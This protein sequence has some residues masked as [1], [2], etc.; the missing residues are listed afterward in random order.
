MSKRKAKKETETRSIEN[1]LIP[2][3]S[4]EALA[5]V[6]GGEVSDA[7]VNVTP[8]VAMSTTAVW[9]AVQLL[10]GAIG[11]LPMDV[12][13]KR[14]SGGRK[15]K[16]NHPIARLISLEPNEDMTWQVFL[17]SLMVNILL[18][19]GGFAW[20]SKRGTDMRPRELMILPSSITYIER[21]EGITQVV[22]GGVT[23]RSTDVIYIPGLSVNGLLGLSPIRY[24][25]AAIG[26]AVAA[27]QQ[28]GS[29][30]ANGSRLSGFLETPAKMSPE[31]LAKLRVSWDKLNVGA[32][33]AFKTAILEEGLKFNASSVPPE[34]A[35]MIETRRFQVTEVARIFNVPPH[36]LADLERATFS[37][38]EQQGISF[39]QY[40]L[41]RWVIRI[42]QEFNRKLF[43]EEER[44]RMFTKMN[45]A[46]LMRGDHAARAE[47]YTKMVNIGAFNINEVRGLE[48][49]N[50]IEGGDVH[51]R[52]LNM[53]PINAPVEPPEPPT[54]PTPDPGPTPEPEP[55]QEPAAEADAVR[56]AWLADV[57]GRMH[58]Q[59]TDQVQRLVRKHLFHGPDAEPEV[60]S[61]RTKL[62]DLLI[63]Q[64]SR[65]A[66]MLEGPLGEA[67]GADEASRHTHD[68]DKR[69][70]EALSQD[71]PGDAIMA[72]LSQ[73]PESPKPL[74]SETTC[75]S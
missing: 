6:G 64:L 71:N 14:A 62:G 58:H 25:K 55:D 44:T 41:M 20:I 34:T 32:K 33:N 74:E 68:W 60:E 35:Q 17:E 50:P 46:A 29:F 38:I 2:I 19:G 51:Y 63:G 27:E 23:L 45:P 10:A 16:S 54:P 69:I 67:G 57:H 70:N 3:S 61:F 37:N 42:E 8:A 49:H 5:Y 11:I 52:P 72:M 40:S 24:G 66:K 1:P 13:E 31:A 12:F 26:L 75:V 15:E 48:D 59:M 39:V 28:A 4:A 30:F 21:R 9:S 22:T 36:M 7:G 18:Y 56:S 53:T 47:Y 65:A 43:R 73:P